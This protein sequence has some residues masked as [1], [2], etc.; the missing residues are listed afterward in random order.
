RQNLILLC[1]LCVDETACKL[2]V[3]RGVVLKLKGVWYTCDT[4]TDRTLVM[5]ALA[6]I[7]RF[8]RPA[9][10]ICYEGFLTCLTDA[11]IEQEHR[12]QVLEVVANLGKKHLPQMFEAG[13]MQK[14]VACFG[15]KVFARRLYPSVLSILAAYS[16]IDKVRDLLLE[17]KG[18]AY[19]LVLDTAFLTSDFSVLQSCITIVSKLSTAV[20]PAELLKANTLLL[21]AYIDKLLKTGPD[22]L[23]LHGLMQL[24]DYLKVD[25][26]FQSFREH[27]THR[28]VE[29]LCNAPYKPPVQYMAGRVLEILTGVRRRSSNFDDHHEGSA[30]SLELRRD[31]SDEN[32]DGKSNDKVAKKVSTSDSFQPAEL[33]TVMEKLL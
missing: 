7:S 30:P 32:D 5:E 21:V 12:E 27:H 33:E 25:H 8:P 6:I 1:K 29:I 14:L 11:L 3:K 4:E 2:M 10:K 9:E 22:G 18:K 20:V 19:T 31:R 23:V 28:V 26:L 16:S 24:Q 17:N 15:D 13:L